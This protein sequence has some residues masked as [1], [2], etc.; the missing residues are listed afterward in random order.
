[1]HVS[2]VLSVVVIVVKDVVDAGKSVILQGYCLCV[3]LFFNLIQHVNFPTHSKNHILDLVIT[4]ACS[5]LAPISI[6]LILLSI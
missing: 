4:S 2:S 3:F 5:S 6:H 1:M